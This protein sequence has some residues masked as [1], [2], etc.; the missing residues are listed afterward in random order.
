MRRIFSGKA[1]FPESEMRFDTYRM[2]I[3]SRDIDILINAM[4]VLRRAS[5]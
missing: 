4:P 2:Q 5:L 1:S 3:A